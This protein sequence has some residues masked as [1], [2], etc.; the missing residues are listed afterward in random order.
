MPSVLKRLLL[1]VFLMSSCILLLLAGELILRP[2]MTINESQGDIHLRLDVES[3]FVFLPHHQTTIHW[4]TDNAAS[5]KLRGLDADLA[6]RIA[7]ADMGYYDFDIVGLDGAEYHYRVYI[8]AWVLNPIRI[9]LTMLG[10]SLFLISAYSLGYIQQFLRWYVRVI[11]PQDYLQSGNSFLDDIRDNRYS[12]IVLCLMTLVLHVVLWQGWPYFQGGD[13]TSYIMT[14]FVAFEG[15]EQTAYSMVFFRGVIPA[16]LNGF[17]LNIGL[18]LTMLT[19]TTL[20][21]VAVVMMYM[22]LLAWCK[23][24]ARFGAIIYI[25]YIPIQLLFHQSSSETSFTWAIIFMLLSLRYAFTQNTGKWWVFVGVGLGL[26]YLS[27]V[28]AIALIILLGTRLLLAGKIVH[29]IRDVALAIFAFVIV[30]SPWVIYRGIKFDYFTTSRS[31][32]TLL[33]TSAYRYN[34]I[35]RGNGTAT[36][37][38]ID[39]IETHILPLPAYQEYNITLDH[40]LS[41]DAHNASRRWAYYRDLIYV[42]DME[43]GWNEAHPFMSRVGLEAVLA[44]PDEFIARTILH[45]ETLL[46]QKAPIAN[47]RPFA[48]DLTD[49]SSRFRSEYNY[50]LTTPEWVE[51]ADMELWEEARQ[52][53]IDLITPIDAIQ[54]NEQVQQQVRQ[55]W[56]FFPDMW[57]LYLFAIVAILRSY[58]STTIYLLVLPLAALAIV[59]PSV[60]IEIFIRFR[61]PVDTIF[62]LL[63]AIGVGES[64]RFVWEVVQR[65]GFVSSRLP[66]NESPPMVV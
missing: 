44:R 6:G 8:W 41:F 54:L 52:R 1:L 23:N 14:Y 26:A 21:C 38:F 58:R 9:I 18:W 37:E 56:R 34:L 31:N 49:D 12:L 27:R 59:V 62:I 22:I 66:K 10:L 29:R 25:L 28:S 15:Y 50:Y 64:I 16:L 7:I 43:V 42:L 13:G 57:V 3:R 24:T 51:S 46:F 45:A 32:G 30:V 48:T 55:F 53:F 33:F 63:F 36:D 40:I 47:G 19:H 39:L 65:M 61:L 11:R 5:V 17:T 60:M 35:Q 4:E 2:N 20:A